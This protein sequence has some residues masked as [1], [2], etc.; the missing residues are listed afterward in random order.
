MPVLQFLKSFD[1]FRLLAV[2]LA[3]FIFRFYWLTEDVI[4]IPSLQWLSIGEMMSNNK[5]LYIDIWTS[6][7]PFSAGTY[8]FVELLFGKSVTALR[9]LSLLLCIGQAIL[10]NYYVS[11]TNIY[12]QKT[13]YPAFFY[14]LFSSI[15][16]DFFALSPVQMG[17]TFM[18]P[19]M[20]FLF[21]D[22]RMGEKSKNHF[23]AGAS[24]GIASLFYLP[25]ACF[26]IFV[27]YSFVVFSS[28]DVKRFFQL[29]AAFAFPW[30][31]VF[32]Y[33][34][35]NGAFYEYANNLIQRAFY[36]KSLFYVNV[37]SI[38]KVGLP[39]VLLAFA[40]FTYTASKSTFL[41]FQ[42][43][44]MKIMVMWFF[45]SMLS[46]FIMRE[47]GFC[48]LYVVVPVFAF[49]TVFLFL[50]IERAWLKEVF[51]WFILIT[52]A[53]LHI[54]NKMIDR[55][56]LAS[57][58]SAMMVSKDAEVRFNGEA[59]R[60]KNILI[61]GQNPVALIHNQQS[62]IYA[63]WNL[64]LLHFGD[65]TNYENI[66]SIYSNVLDDKPEFILD[67]IGMMPSLIERIPEFEKFYEPSY[68]GTVFRLKK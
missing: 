56:L 62:T 65:L 38:I 68:D 15:S 52:F 36:S 39:S 18:L 11:Q 42:Y 26:L 25:F 54:Q 29:M 48:N 12:D 53:I 57:N 20:Y 58:K 47:W 24:L 35:L 43:S 30:L 66:S 33:Y 9:I 22:V 61:L 44:S 59:I 13:S 27:I 49:F 8:Y 10:F 55:D 32:S 31:M 63:S 34:Y 14:V 28:F 5:M 40:A 21:K 67:E 7:E 6:L 1:P 23:F 16:Y 37:T 51:F 17:L 2:A 3:A 45:N 19:V 41:N 64:S 50:E 4:L 46:F 60:N